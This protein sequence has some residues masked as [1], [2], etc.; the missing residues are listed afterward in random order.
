M[1]ITREMERSPRRVRARVR[2]FACDGRL[3]GSSLTSASSRD[4]ENGKSL[5]RRR[6]RCLVRPY[7]LDHEPTHQPD[8]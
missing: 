4:E 3:I 8:S 5:Y 6:R 2:G 7:P 1:C